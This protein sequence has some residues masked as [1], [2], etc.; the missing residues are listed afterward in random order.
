M[1]QIFQVTSPEI[2]GLCINAAANQVLAYTGNTTS[3]IYADDTATFEEFT[4]LAAAGTRATA[5]QAD[6]DLAEIFGSYELT[7]VN[8]SDSQVSAIAGTAATINSEFSSPG[9]ETVYYQWSLNGVDIAGK[10]S[11]SISNSSVTEEMGGE[12]TCTA[13][14]TAADGSVGTAVRTFSVAISKSL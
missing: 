10:T 5:V 7:P 4:T 8:V 14:A 12:Y 6:F 11:S 3:K 13:T 2:C 9:G 1:A